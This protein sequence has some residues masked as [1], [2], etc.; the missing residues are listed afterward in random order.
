MALHDSATRRALLA[1]A[2]T[3]RRGGAGDADAGRGDPGDAAV[4]GGDDGGDR[5][6]GGGVASEPAAGGDERAGDA[7]VAGEDRPGVTATG[8]DGRSAGAADLAPG[9]SA[10][11]VAQ[12]NLY[13]TTFGGPCGG[14]DKVD[15]VAAGTGLQVTAACEDGNGDRWV[16]VASDS[17]GTLGWVDAADLAPTSS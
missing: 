11:V 6:T 2:G 12:T 4:G 9:D 13:E 16:E 14:A 15:E 8:G 3:A 10:T 1:F 17:G 5:G 7:A